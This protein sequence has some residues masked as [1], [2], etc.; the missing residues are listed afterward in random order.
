M[1]DQ[2]CE[3]LKADIDEHGLG[4]PRIYR[5]EGKCLDGNSRLRACRDQPK[6]RSGRV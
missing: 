3:A 2:E 5:Y 1:T 4:D 6:P